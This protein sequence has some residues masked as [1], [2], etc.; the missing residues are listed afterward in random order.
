MDFFLRLL[1]ILFT[2]AKT[3]GKNYPGTSSHGEWDGDY[4][5]GYREGYDDDY[6]A[7]YS[8]TLYDYEKPYDERS[9]E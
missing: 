6:N 4:K 8:G 2:P 5:L 1:V 3:N 7:P 9:V